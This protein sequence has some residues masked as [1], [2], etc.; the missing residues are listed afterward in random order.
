MLLSLPAHM[1]LKV[2]STCFYDYKKDLPFAR[3]VVPWLKYSQLDTIIVTLVQM[4][5]DLVVL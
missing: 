1:H 5:D 3:E 2:S 4:N